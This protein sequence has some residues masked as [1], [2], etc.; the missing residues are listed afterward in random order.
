MEREDTQK[1]EHINV[2]DNNNNKIENNVGI[3]VN[4]ANVILSKVS[5][6]D[7]IPGNYFNSKIYEITMFMQGDKFITENEANLLTN[8][9]K[10]NIIVKKVTDLFQAENERK[11]FTIMLNNETKSKFIVK[12]FGWFIVT[13]EDHKLFTKIF[14]LILPKLRL[15][16]YDYIKL[17]KHQIIEAITFLKSIGL[18]HNDLNEHNFMINDEVNIKIRQD[19]KVG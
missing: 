13:K 15:A 12:P 1:V 8:V 10:C 19:M 18:R 11:S 4:I 14:Y 9:K 2:F 7:A 17:N 16:Q 6:L 5:N 3:E